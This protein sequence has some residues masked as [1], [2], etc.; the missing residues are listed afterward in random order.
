MVI[1]RSSIP[2]SFLVVIAFWFVSS[3]ISNA[4]TYTPESQLATGPYWSPDGLKLAFSAS[5]N[6]NYEVYVLNLVDNSKERITDH[7]AND[8]YPVWSPNGLDIAFFSD[9]KSHIPPHPPD[10]IVYNIRGLYET[11]ARD[12]YLPSWSPDGKAILAH[13]RSER[14]N[15]EIYTMDK[16]AR[17]R[18]SLTWNMATD[19]HPRFSPNGKKIVFVSDRDFQ[20]EIYIMNADGTG[21][22]R[23]TFSPAY[24]IDPI[25]SPDG[26]QI[27]YISNASGFFDI[28][29]M[30]ADGSK[31]RRLT[32]TPSYDISP[33]WSP[34][35]KQILFASDRED[36]VFNLFIMDIYGDNIRRLTSGE[37]NEYYGS[38]SPNGREI[39]YLTTREGQTQLHLIRA[40]GTK[41]KRLT[42]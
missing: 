41:S 12:G 8:L 32:D 34:D 35:G 40:D 28:Y 23:L 16:R 37:G 5:Y 19:V 1:S 20:P 17:N 10:T 4:Q 15:Y 18:T 9:R 36:G 31:K 26:H 14:G 33:V 13:L 29:V 24:T 6:G 21:Q 7:P 30:N 22:K 3:R 2:I 11:Y 38:W 27:A 25:W 42:R 39:A